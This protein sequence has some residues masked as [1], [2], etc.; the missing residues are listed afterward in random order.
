MALSTKK[1][2]A[3]V[4][5]A[6]LASPLVLCPLIGLVH[7]GA[8]PDFRDTRA[9]YRW[10]DG[11]WTPTAQFPGGTEGVAISASGAVWA[12]TPM[13]KG[14]NRWDGARWVHYKGSDF[15]L[16][17]R[18]GRE[19]YG[20]GAVRDALPGGFAIKGDEVW[21]A[22]R[23]GVAR[24]DSRGWRMYPE[25]VKTQGAV[26]T[27]AGPSGVWVMDEDANLSHFDGE[28]WSVENLRNTPP[29]V[30]WDDRVEENLPE[31]RETADGAVWLLLGGLWRMDG[32]GWRY[33]ERDDINWF[34]ATMIGQSGDRVWLHDDPHIFELKPDGGTGRVF[35]RRELPI[36]RDAAI[37]RLAADGGKIWLATAKDLLAFDGN[38]WRR[39]GIPPGTAFVME[40]AAGGD[41]S[42]W[43]VAEK[44]SI[45]R[46]VGWLAPPMAACALGLLVVGTLLVMWVKG[47]AEDRLSAD[48][49]V[50]QA[51]GAVPGL[52]I[53]ARQ[54]EVKKQ[55]RALW[56]KMP[57]FLIAF[58]CLMAAGGWIHRYL[59]GV[60][61][62]APEWLL[63]A[64]ALAPVAVPGAFLAWR[65]LRAWRKPR[66]MFGSEIRLVGFAAVFF[67]LVG[68]LPLRLPQS[69]VGVI[70]FMFGSIF[71]FMVMLQARNIL[72]VRLTKKLW[73]SGE[74]DRA[75]ARLRWVSFGNP[76]PVMFVLEGAIYASLAGRG[77]EAERCLRRALSEARGTDAAF[78]AHALMCLG[79]TLTDRGRYEESQRCFET[80]VAMGDRTGGARIGL[81]ELLLKQGT[82]P[83]KALAL[84]EEGMKIKKNRLARP[85]R[86]GSR[87]WA[88]GA[89]GRQ[90]EMDEAMATALRET[91][92][93][94]KT[95]A[96]GVHW[97]IGKALVACQRIAEA[98]EHFQTAFQTDPL[99]QSGASSRME[100]ERYGAGPGTVTQA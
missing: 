74:Y 15:E 21:A 42:A 45:L 83:E 8:Q 75:L 96:A 32:A 39:R 71:L 14:I 47:M 95:V 2:R 28:T 35:D 7:P 59:R 50:L 91:D 78:R 93:S 98:I 12:T 54:A 43:V 16:G 10:H 67:F 17:G 51:A 25:A 89:M 84:I 80:V 55:S 61:P 86:M 79:F 44:R 23:E 82:E 66:R 87:A 81:A 20:A 46:I 76:T 62:G 13:G 19:H 33:I 64:C 100:L 63:G 65:W 4:Q 57:L 69:L 88:L 70:V 92:P 77:E 58:P 97:R 31:L 49:A 22:A 40:V 34:D 1:K 36:G 37:Y 3:V 90:R 73:L 24:F 56:W 60:W 38:E 99:G 30:A 94:L 6:L 41:G 29:G 26:A 72:A 52:N 48:R 18:V 9:V 85:E 68:R 53:A 27:A 5:I 11:K